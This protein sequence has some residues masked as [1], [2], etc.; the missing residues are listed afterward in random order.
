MTLRWISLVPPAMERHG[1]RGSPDVHRRGVVLGGGAPGP[2]QLEADLLRPLLVL[3]AEQL[4]HARLRARARRPPTARS[5]VR[6]ARAR[7]ATC[8]SASSPPSRSSTSGSSSCPGLAR[9]GS[10][11]ASTPQPNDEPAAHRHPLVGERGAGQRA[12]RRRRRRPR[13][14]RARTRRSRNTSLN[15]ATP[16]SSRSGRTSMPGGVHVDEEVGD[17]RVLRRVGVGAGEADAP[18]RRSGAIDVHTFCPVSAS[19]RRRVA[20]RGRSDARSLPASGLA[21]HLA[22]A[23]LAAQRRPHPPLLLL[24]GAVAR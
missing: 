12:S 23:D 4:A 10:S 21:E 9:P 19:R 3:D 6:G 13:S 15:I 11:S 24:G 16:V 7:R 17:A 8:A 1:C 5:V 2:E 14:R 20:A 22:P 18:S